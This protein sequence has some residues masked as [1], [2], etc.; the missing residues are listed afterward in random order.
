MEW[1]II[2]N[3]SMTDM[4]T[5]GAQLRGQPWKRDRCLGLTVNTQTR[6]CGSMKVL[7]GAIAVL[8]IGA[9]SA[10]G[11]FTDS[12]GRVCNFG[13]AHDECQYQFLEKIP[14]TI[15]NIHYH[16][17]QKVG[18]VDGLT[19][20]VYHHLTAEETRLVYLGVRDI[21]MVGAKAVETRDVLETIVIVKRM[22]LLHENSN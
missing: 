1:I 5:D 20:G 14:G 19:E 11:V 12:Q 8:M 6:G 9:Q 3:S 2:H 13:P 16:S 21:H 17:G 22:L 10:Y 18:Y 7:L 15:N 4:Y